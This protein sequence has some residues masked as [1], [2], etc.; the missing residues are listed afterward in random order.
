MRAP[1]L[2]NV[3]EGHSSSQAI[4]LPPLRHQIPDADTGNRGRD[5]FRLG[6]DTWASPPRGTRL[7]AGRGQRHG[8]GFIILGTKL[9]NARP[10]ELRV[11]FPSLCYGP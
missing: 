7:P 6:G 10:P 1:G 3:Q 5:G 2:Q 11:P 4:P 9:E 8:D